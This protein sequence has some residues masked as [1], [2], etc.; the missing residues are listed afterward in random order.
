MDSDIS[1][2]SISY[3]IS[4]CRTWFRNNARAVEAER[5]DSYAQGSSDI[6]ALIVEN[7]DLSG[8]A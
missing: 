2:C 3:W 1:Q 6:Q 4:L 5:I 8:L 7:E